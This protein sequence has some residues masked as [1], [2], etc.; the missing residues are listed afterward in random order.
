MYLDVFGASHINEHD[1]NV[2]GIIGDELFWTSIY[3][4]S[5]AEGHIKKTDLT[6]KVTTNLHTGNRLA[7]YPGVVES[8][9]IWAGGEE[10]DGG[11][12][13]RASIAKIL[14]DSVTVTRHPNTDDCNEFATLTSDGTHI[15][16]G[17]RAPGGISDASNWP[18]GKGLWKIPIATWTDTGTWSREYEDAQSLAWTSIAKI[19][20][21]WYAYLATDVSGRWKVIKSTNLSSWSTELDYTDQTV[22]YNGRGI[23]ITTGTKLVVLTSRS[24]DHF[25]MH[26]FD[27]SSWTDYDLGLSVTQDFRINGWWDSDRSKVVITVSRIT[28]KQYNIYQVN[29]DNTQ[30]ETLH[31]NQAGNVN[32]IQSEHY[33][34]ATKSNITY[35]AATSYISM[36]A[37]MMRLDQN[38]DYHENW[39]RSI[40]RFKN[41]PI[42]PDVTRRAL[43]LGAR[44]ATT[45][46][47]SKN[48]TETPI[49]MII[50]S[51]TARN[52][53]IT[54]GVYVKLDTTSST[55]SLIEPGDEVKTLGGQYFEVKTVKP[56]WLGDKLVKHECDL[57]LLPLHA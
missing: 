25:H 37:Y 40:T 5:S 13:F 18:N 20:A 11:D 39:S 27:G 34:D 7:M 31:I 44:D 45:G 28:D 30:L 48:Y 32:D 52:L 3:S 14:T 38:R 16:A 56:H 8:T 57:T 17:E 36:F 4:A 29:I 33:A 15:V 51:A 41:L 50:K 53:A 35:F 23:M 26:V 22:S 24:D 12:I 1:M 42:D 55:I 47:R 54:P 43:V 9:W 21:T 49:E 19:G 6:S 10:R 46:W 2:Y